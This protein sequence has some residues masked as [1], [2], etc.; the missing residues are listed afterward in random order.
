MERRLAE[1]RADIIILDGL[2]KPEEA[3]LIRKR[4]GILLYISASPEVRFA[5]RRQD[6]ETTDERGMS[7][8][9]FVRQDNLPTEVSIRTVGET[10]ADY[11]IENN[12][13]V[14]EFEANIKEFL[15]RHGFML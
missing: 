5:R 11:R 6:A 9:Q 7:W 13:T 15:Q 8:E 1:I 3:A 12:G 14:E 4:D 10:M 2:R